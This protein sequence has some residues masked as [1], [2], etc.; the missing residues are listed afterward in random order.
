MARDVFTVVLLEQQWMVRFH[1]RHRD[2]ATQGEAISAAVDAAY[3]AGLANQNSGGERVQDTNNVF[4][5]EWTYGIDPPRGHAD[6][7]GLTTSRFGECGTRRRR[8]WPEHSDDDRAAEDDEA[9]KAPGHGLV[10]TMRHTRVDPLSAMAQ[11]LR[12]PPA[13]QPRRDGFARHCPN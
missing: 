1:G 5:T 13:C 8:K 9:E 3:K 7:A 10:P 4:R 12:R 2:D 11:L 6:R